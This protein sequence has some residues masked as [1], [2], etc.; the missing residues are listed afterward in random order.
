M[1]AVFAASSMLGPPLGGWLAA[2][3]GWRWA[4]WINLPVG[5]L[6]IALA[7]VFLQL[8]APRRRPFQLD[9]WG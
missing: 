4:F 7:A 3:V 9:I 2:S 6:A 1:G 8:P 5:G